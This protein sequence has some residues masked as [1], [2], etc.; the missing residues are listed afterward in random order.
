MVRLTGE[1][2]EVVRFVEAES[3]KPSLSRQV[4]GRLGERGL[5]E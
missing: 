1:E 5:G 2:G 3:L 4:G